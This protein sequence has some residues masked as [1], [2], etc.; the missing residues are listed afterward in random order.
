MASTTIIGFGNNNPVMCDA[1]HSIR[2]R[3]IDRHLHLLSIEVLE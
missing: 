2:P 3:F 1:E